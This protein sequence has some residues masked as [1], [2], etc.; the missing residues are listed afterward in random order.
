[1]SPEEE[2]F[3]RSLQETFKVEADEH[4]QSMAA[5]LLELEKMP[6]PEDLRRLVEVI[7]RSAHSLKGAARAVSNNEI[8]GICQK[9]EDQFARWKRGEIAPSARRWKGSVAG[10]GNGDFGKS[11]GE[12]GSCEKSESRPPSKLSVSKFHRQPP[13]WESPGAPFLIPR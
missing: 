7:F 5:S 9:L 4:I 8:E 11:D 13:H 1:M 12:E 10:S 2:D 3:L 6:S